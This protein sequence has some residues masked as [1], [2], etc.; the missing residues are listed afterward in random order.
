MCTDPFFHTPNR[1]VSFAES[2]ED[3]TC[4]QTTTAFRP[5]QAPVP[6]SYKGFQYHHSSMTSG[7]ANKCPLLWGPLAVVT[8]Y[9]S[10][11]VLS[12]SGW[13]NNISCVNETTFYQSAHRPF[14][15]F[16]LVAVSEKQGWGQHRKSHSA[17]MQTLQCK[18]CKRR[19]GWKMCFSMF[20]L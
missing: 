4:P 2:R 19:H 8:S 15:S 12:C 14:L 18:R 9:S 16:L 17:G 13:G 10:K 7:P 20:I 6:L 1:Q 5:K 11:S 3:H